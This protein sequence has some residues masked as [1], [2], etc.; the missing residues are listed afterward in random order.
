MV[1]A[2]IRNNERKVEDL[3]VQVLDEDGNFFTDELEVVDLVTNQNTEFV[4]GEKVGGLKPKVLES[5][6]EANPFVREA[7]VFRDLKGNVKVE[8]EQSK[9][10]A[11]V[12]TNGQDDRY[13][14][15]DGR[16]LPVNAR[17]TARV[18]LLE[19]EFPFGWETMLESNYSRQVYQLLLHIENDEFWSAQIAHMKIKTDGE[20][21]LYPQVTKQTILFGKPK[22]VEEKFE[23]LMTF[24]KK[25]LPNKGWN[26]YETV[27]VKFKNQ[28]ICE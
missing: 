11:R 16:V 1:F 4:V 2:G 9:P 17:H 26:S 7:Q 6:V 13:I 21:E 20:I 14:D 15:A 12:F 22:D 25:I 18:P 27:N 24:Y 10:I 19:T 23:K 5:R 8:V 3:L 28:I